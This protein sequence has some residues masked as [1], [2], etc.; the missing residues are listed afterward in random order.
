MKTFIQEQ[1]LQKNG[2]KKLSLRNLRRISLRKDNLMDS[3][4]EY[5]RML[6]NIK[7]GFKV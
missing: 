2:P 6:E 5:E 1:I 3:L 4:M 7:K